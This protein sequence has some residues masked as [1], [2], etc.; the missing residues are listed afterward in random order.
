MNINNKE[1]PFYRYK[2]S[3]IILTTEGKNQNTRTIIKNY[4]MICKE[5]K[6]DQELLSVFF[7][8]QLCLRTNIGQNHELII[9]KECDK[10]TLQETL[11]EYIKHFIMCK[12]CNN[13]ETKILSDS[14]MLG[15]SCS[16]CGSVSEI[17]I[18]SKFNKYYDYLLKKLPKTN[19]TIKSN[20]AH[21]EIKKIELSDPEVIIKNFINDTTTG[22]DLYFELQRIK[23]SRELNDNDIAMMLTKLYITNK[24]NI[25]VET[26]KLI[27]CKNILDVIV[28]V[29]IENKKEIM[30]SDIL[31]ELRDDCINENDILEWIDSKKDNNNNNN[32]INKYIQIYGKWL[33]D[34][35]DE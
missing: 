25:Y 34:T 31:E 15:L 7:S 5:L 8:H 9:F 28:G 21:V 17:I 13:P 19:I 35:D 11:K 18:T 16:A 23:V 1:D 24:F 29:L 12:S 33:R 3:E 30:I 6:R 14:K 4:G 26:M 2:M 27:K 22:R 10:P 32:M 20:V